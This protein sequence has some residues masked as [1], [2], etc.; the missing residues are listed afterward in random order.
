MPNYD[1]KCTAC[2]FVAED[3][4]L[5]IADRDL[6]CTEPCPLC[7]CVGT[8]IRV[9]S[10]PHIGDAM[11]QGRTHLPTTWTNKLAEMKSKHRRSTIAIPSS[12]REL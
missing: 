10:A 3:I 2:D 11:R 9:I 1:F 8:I 6:P 7:E 12:K 4:Q 5:V